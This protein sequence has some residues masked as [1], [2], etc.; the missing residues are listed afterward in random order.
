MLK[1]QGFLLEGE[2]KH[3]VSQN[4]QCYQEDEY[5]V[6]FPAPLDVVGAYEYSWLWTMGFSGD[7]VSTSISWKVLCV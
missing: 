2:N 3:Q 5:F 4:K 1:C 7:S 6:S